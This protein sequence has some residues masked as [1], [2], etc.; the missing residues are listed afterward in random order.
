[1][2]FQELL[3]YAADISSEAGFA[4]SLTTARRVEPIGE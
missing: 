2:V 3:H 4:M 1:M